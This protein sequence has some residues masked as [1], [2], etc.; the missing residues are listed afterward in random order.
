MSWYTE[1]GAISTTHKQKS[2]RFF[3]MGAR[4][5]EVRVTVPA[6]AGGKRSEGGKPPSVSKRK[7]GCRSHRCGIRAARVGR[8]TAGRKS[9]REVCNQ[10]ES[11]PVRPDIPKSSRERYWNHRWGRPQL[12][13]VRA[14]NRVAS[15]APAQRLIKRLP[16]EWPVDERG[17]THVGRVRSYVR[18]SAPARFRAGVVNDIR[19]FKSRWHGVARRQVELGIVSPGPWLCSSPWK[20]L[21]VRSARHGDWELLLEAVRPDDVGGGPSGPSFPPPVQLTRSSGRGGRGTRPS[22]RGSTR[23]RG[24]VSSRV[25]RLFD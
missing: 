9:K 19:W 10:R 11:A 21:A 15:S 12:W 18:L 7:R 24:S 8:S 23:S 6:S 4:I 16:D 22:P 3:W 20:F 2:G 13:A 5:V 1:W 25:R 17:D 14:A